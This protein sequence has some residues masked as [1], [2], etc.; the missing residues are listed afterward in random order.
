MFLDSF[1]P[2]CAGEGNDAAMECDGSILQLTRECFFFAVVSR[3]YKKELKVFC[4]A[5]IV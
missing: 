2:L 1:L 4:G 5:P 3:G